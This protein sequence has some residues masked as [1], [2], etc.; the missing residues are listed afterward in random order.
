V[1]TEAQQRADKVLKDCIFVEW[2][3]VR[4]RIANEIDD[5]VAQAI[6]RLRSEMG[7]E[8]DDERLG[9]VTIQINREA[10]EELNA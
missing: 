7:V 6:K 10:W 2:T 1:D 3:L 4:D 9:Y 5:A 8:F